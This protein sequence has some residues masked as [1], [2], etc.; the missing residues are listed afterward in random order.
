MQVTIAIIAFLGLV[1][2]APAG[3]PTPITVETSLVKYN[4]LTEQESFG[5]VERRDAHP[6][7]EKRCESDQY[8]SNGHCQRTDCT[9]HFGN[10]DYCVIYKY[11]TTC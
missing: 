5:L 4:D 6:G 8:C 2:A 1:S 3:M 7:I 11:D 10:Q 9:G